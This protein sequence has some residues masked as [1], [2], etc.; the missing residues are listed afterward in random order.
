[1][2]QAQAQVDGLQAQIDVQTSQV[3]S[4][5]SHA[6]AEASAVQSARARLALAQATQNRLTP[7]AAQGFVTR[8]AL[9]QARTETRSAEHRCNRPCNRLLQRVRPYVAWR[10]CVQIWRLQKP[11]FVKRSAICA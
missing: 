10:L 1:M 5:I 6:G 3:S 11:S 7:L 2:Q 4:Q 8:E 9:D